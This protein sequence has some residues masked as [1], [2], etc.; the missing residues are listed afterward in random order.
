MLE[1]A[2]KSDKPLVEPSKSLTLLLTIAAVGAEVVLV[3]AVVL[4]V[5]VIDIG[6]VLVSASIVGGG[7]T[8]VSSVDPVD[9]DITNFSAL[10]AASD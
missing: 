3:V 4:V 10:I 1:W 8:V 2:S 5:V 9:V 7:F 6:L